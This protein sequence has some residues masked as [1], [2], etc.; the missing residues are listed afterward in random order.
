MRA[1]FCVVY[2]IVFTP[3]VVSAMMEKRNRGLEWGL[4]V[5]QG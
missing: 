1:R 3:H 5:A 2:V 4:E